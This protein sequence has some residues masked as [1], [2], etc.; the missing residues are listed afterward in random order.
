MLV[1]CECSTIPYG[2]IGGEAG[3]GGG[4]REG[5]FEHEAREALA[6]KKLLAVGDVDAS[7][8]AEL[9][10]KTR[11]EDYRESPHH[12]DQFR[13]GAYVYANGSGGTMVHKGVFRGERE[14][15]PESDVHKRSSSR[16]LS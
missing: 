12:W 15:R 1:Y 2:I 4:S 5:N 3:G 13:G 7:D 9:V 11:S 6:E 16:E 10:L 8:V 14:G